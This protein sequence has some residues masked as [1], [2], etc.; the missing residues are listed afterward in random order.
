[1]KNSNKLEELLTNA[2]SEYSYECED[3]D[4]ECIVKV[5]CEEGWAK[6]TVIENNKNK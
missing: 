6:A 4:F 5:T 1:M 2:A 3:K